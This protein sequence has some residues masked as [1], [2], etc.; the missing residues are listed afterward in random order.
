MNTTEEIA[1]YLDSIKE[2]DSRAYAAATFMTNAVGNRFL[3]AAAKELTENVLTPYTLPLKGVELLLGAY[4]KYDSSMKPVTQG[5]KLAGR[6]GKLII[7][8]MAGPVGVAVGG[9]MVGFSVL[10]IINDAEA[11]AAKKS[12]QELIDSMAQKLEA[13]R[14]DAQKRAEAARQ[15]EALAQDADKADRRIVLAVAGGKKFT[16]NEKVPMINFFEEMI[17]TL[18]SDDSRQSLLQRYKELNDSDLA[19]IYYLGADV[20]DYPEKATPQA[21][22]N[23][24]NVVLALMQDSFEANVG[25]AT[26]RDGQTSVPT[27]PGASASRR[28]S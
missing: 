27:F 8:S 25:D 21:K 22:M 7:L 16:P 14:E 12:E 3:A 19:K 2:K 28:S 6:F 10:A 11:Q 5:V 18:P 15:R 24:L 4:T 23:F 13:I 17:G 9:A 26:E 20:I 1:R